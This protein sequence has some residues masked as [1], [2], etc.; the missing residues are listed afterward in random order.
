MSAAADVDGVTA[1][2]TISGRD[3]ESYTG[4]AATMPPT[5]GF[6]TPADDAVV[7]TA[8][9]ALATALDRDVE[10]G[11]WTFATDGGHLAHAGITCIGFAPGQEQHAHTIWDQ[12][13]IAEMEEALIGNAMLAMTLGAVQSR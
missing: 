3:V 13:G 11:T 10:V 4:I 12:I 1:R 2:V 9:S 8:Q 5:R 6:E 7:L